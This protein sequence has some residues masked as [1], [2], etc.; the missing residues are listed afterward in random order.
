MRACLVHTHP[1]V[2]LVLRPAQGTGTCIYRARSTC[3]RVYTYTCTNFEVSRPYNDHIQGRIEHVVRVC[4]LAPLQRSHNES[5]I[6]QQYSGTPGV[7]SNFRDY[8]GKS[9]RV[10]RSAFQCSLPCCTHT[11]THTCNFLLGE[12]IACIIIPFMQ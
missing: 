2:F 12:A 9:G 4:S 3:M 10:G 1:G 6:M 5:G 11:H 8:P 7:K